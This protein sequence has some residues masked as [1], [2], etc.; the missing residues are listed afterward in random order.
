[1]DFFAGDSNSTI[2]FYYTQTD[3]GTYTVNGNTGDDLF[4]IYSIRVSDKPVTY[5]DYT[6]YNN[7]GSVHFTKLDNTHDVGTFNFKAINSVAPFD[8]VTITNGTF[9]IAR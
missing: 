7:S 4:A 8:T 6:S 2:E 9:N 5:N 3:T 1:M